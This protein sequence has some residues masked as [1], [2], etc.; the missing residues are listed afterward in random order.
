VKDDDIITAN[1]H[2]VTCKACVNFLFLGNTMK[3]EPGSP[4]VDWFG[5]E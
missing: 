4:K 1:E 3:P 5:D 2:R